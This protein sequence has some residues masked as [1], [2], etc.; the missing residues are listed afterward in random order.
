MARVFIT[1]REI[2]FIND[3]A[4]EV[5][6][7]VIGQKI[8]Y[9]P[10][11]EKKSKIHDI[12]E[13]SSQKVFE[14][15]IEIDALVKYAPQD[16]RANT[17]GSEEYYTIEVY[18]QE[19]DMLDK[20]ITVLEGD[21]FSYGSVFFEV[22]SAPDSNT[23]YGQV[24]HKGFMTITGKQARV[25]QFSSHIFGPTD[26]KYSDKDAVQNTFVQQ[27]GFSSNIQGKT[28][29]VRALQKNG[30]LTEP[31]S[32]PDEVSSKGDSTGAGSAFYGDDC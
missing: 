28:G 18:V 17:F 15:P 13:E 7:D 2:N 16:V 32:G 29:D 10:I 5:V 12:Y 14:N 30:V 9:F 4:K 11:S 8:Y 20:G 3:I 1:P 25:G 26:E 22:I 21:F 6:K 23:I 31:I 19:R 24:E 27:R